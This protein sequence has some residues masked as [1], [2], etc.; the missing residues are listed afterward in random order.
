MSSSKTLLGLVA[1][2]AIGAIAGILLAPDKGSE[3]RKRIS[4]KTGDL[5][6][7]V[8]NSFGEFID[9]VKNTYSK[10]DDNMEDFEASSRSKMSGLKEDFK[11]SVDNSF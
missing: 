5:A 8:K 11:A 6:D 10:A 9:Q 2:A 4:S 3:T 1:G 7:N